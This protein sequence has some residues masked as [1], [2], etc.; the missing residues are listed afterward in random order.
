MSVQVEPRDAAILATRERV[1]LPGYEL[2]YDRPVHLVR[3]EGSHLFDP[4]G[5]RYLDAYNNVVSVGHCH[6]HVVEAVSRQVATLNTHTRYLHEGIVDYSE[7]L[8][9][10]MPAGIDRVL[11]VCTGSEAN[12][13]A[14]RI[15]AHHTGTT[16]VIITADAYHGNTQAVAA[17]SPDIGG[18]VRPGPHVRAVP[19]PDSYRLPA[20]GLATRFA[21]DVG[22]AIEELQAGGFGLSCLIVD[23]IFSSDGIFPDPSVLGPAV[24]LVHEAGGLFIGDEV[25]PGF[26]RTGERMWGFER[27]QVTPDLVTIGKPMGNGLPVAAVTVGTD[28]LDEFARDVPYFNTYA[29]NPVSMAAADAVLDVIEDEGL[30]A[31]AAWVGGALRA[32]LERLTTDHPQVGDVRGVGLYIGIEIVT[33]RESGT[34]DPQAASRIVNALR[35]RRVLLAT[36]GPHGN[37]LKI[38]PPLVF[39]MSDADWLATA[40]GEVLAQGA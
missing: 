20:D 13:L 36:S 10:L 17:V 5:R 11:H 7:R 28:V 3:G 1:L 18:T 12:D 27:H 40:L 37:V 31:N 26:G 22:H 2:F 25:Q 19:A 15:A 35:D 9:A 8:L 24:R 34:P 32:E 16:G 33:D 14:L 30:M 21:A 39:S 23:S 6:P 29:G 4:D 38:R